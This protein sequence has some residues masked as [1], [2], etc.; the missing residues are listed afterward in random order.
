LVTYFSLIAWFSL[1]FV[2]WF[3]GFCRF[4]PVFTGFA[5]WFSPVFAG[6]AG[7]TV[8]QLVFVLSFV[9]NFVVSSIYR[10]KQILFRRG[11]R[12]PNLSIPC[13]SELARTNTAMETLNGVFVAS[14]EKRYLIDSYYSTWKIIFFL[15]H[16]TNQNV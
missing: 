12:A 6:F 4:F 10:V 7:L 5:G 8:L 13:W 16:L 1:G 9:V 15:Q 14:S 2:D 11:R 3:F